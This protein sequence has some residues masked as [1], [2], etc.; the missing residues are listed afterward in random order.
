MMKHVTTFPLGYKRGFRVAPA[1]RANADRPLL[2]SFAGHSRSDMRRAMLAALGPLGPSRTHISSGFD[3][4][5]GL[6][7]N[8]YREQLESSL[9]APCPSGFSTPDTF[10]FCES[11]EAGCIPIVERGAECDYYRSWLGDHPALVV[12]RWDQAPELMD[13]VVTSG[14]AER[15]RQ[16]CIQWWDTAKRAYQHLFA[17]R[18]GKPR[19]PA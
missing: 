8:A 13:R 15:L 5:D 1:A 11:L 3:A 2:W 7:Q 14:E 9:F 10:R 12:R 6:P 16:S 17:Q 19:P 18:I 4:A